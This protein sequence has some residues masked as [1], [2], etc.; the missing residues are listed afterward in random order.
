MGLDFLGIVTI[1]M[2]RDLV[3]ED[4]MG[5]GR[6]WGDWMVEERGVGL[7]EVLVI[8]VSGVKPPLGVG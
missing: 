2:A 8:L 1:G 6:L 7:C 5:E 4:E 3:V